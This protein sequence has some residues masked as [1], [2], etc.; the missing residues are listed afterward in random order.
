M[1][2]PR[3]HVDVPLAAGLVTLPA[4]ASRHVQVLRLQPGS[5]LTLFDGRGGEWSAQVASIGRRDVQAQVSAHS[6]A[7][8]ELARTVTLALGMPANERMDTVVE[9]AAELG[10]AALQ[11]LVTQR[12][13]LRPEGERAERRRAHWQAV[14]V[15]ACE[16]CGRNRVP[17]VAPVHTLRDWLRFGLRREI[18]LEGHG[19]T[20]PTNDGAL[21]AASGPAGVALRRCL[22]QGQL[23]RRL[24]YEA[25]DHGAAG[26]F[27]HEVLARAAIHALA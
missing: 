21:A 10:A 26:H 17:A 18:H 12:S 23:R 13:V 24:R 22:G 3:V 7:E 1:A 9:K 15:A 4:A 8:R 20:G 25:P 14:A 2:T 19:P 6:A 27:H 5:A 16:Q 11:P